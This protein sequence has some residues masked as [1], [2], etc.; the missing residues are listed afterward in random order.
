MK[1]T[2]LLAAFATLVATAGF[3]QEAAGPY[4]TGS[5]GGLF[6]DANT[7]G[8]LSLGF[9]YMTARRIGLEIELAWAPSILKQ[10]DARIATSEPVF[11]DIAIFPP[12]E[13]RTRS[14]LLTLQTNVVGV[15]PGSGTRLRAFVDAGGGIADVHRRTHL[16]TAIPNFP[17]FSDTLSGHGF[18]PIRFSPIERDFSSSVAA[19]VLG[20]GG[21][22]EY[23]LGERISV[24]THVRYQHL[25]TSGDA[26][27]MAR[28]EGRLR[29]TW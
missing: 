6:G 19:L 22:F 15:L 20:G 25:F 10:P 17:D 12:I 8:S 21:G 7:T 18:S 2:L 14:R 5:G 13:L 27:D 11:S 29:W 23:A 16:R 28:L 4:L 9:G 26:L 3:A 1:R 24:G